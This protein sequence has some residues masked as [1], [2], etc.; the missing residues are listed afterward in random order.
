MSD[1]QD[2]HGVLESAI[3]STVNGYVDPVTK[4]RGATALAPRVGM[5]P[6]TLSNKANPL[7]EHQ[8]TCAESIPVQLV[9]NDFRILY[10]LAQSLGHGTYKLPNA[11]TV[12]DVELLNTYCELHARVGDM[13][14]QIRSS[15]RDGR[16]QLAEL[17]P[18]RA[19][20]DA[21]VRAGLGVVARIEALAQ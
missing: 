5:V 9:A 19:A 14:Q 15:L 13:A 8:L 17:P 3:Y 1:I 10:A 18:L 21:L 20:F 12:S 11:A 4:Q 6:G 16:V 7:Q 2:L